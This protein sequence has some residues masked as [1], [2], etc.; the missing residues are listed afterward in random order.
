VRG[1][2]PLSGVVAT[3]LTACASPNG[4]TFP[5]ASL[6]STTHWYSVPLVTVESV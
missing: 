1:G 3:K 4:V 5:S 6:V 2:A